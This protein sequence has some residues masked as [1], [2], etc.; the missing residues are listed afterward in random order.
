[1]SYDECSKWYNGYH[2]S[3]Y[4]LYSPASVVSAMRNHKYDDYWI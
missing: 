4:E 3:E 2:L 1:M